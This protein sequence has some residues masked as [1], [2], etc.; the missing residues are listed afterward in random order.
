MRISRVHAPVTVLGPGRRVGVWVQ[1]C[2]L[3]CAGCASRD[4]WDPDGGREVATDDLLATILDLGADCDGLTVSGG[5]PLQQA[6]DLAQLLAAIRRSPTARAREWDILLF[7]GLA[8]HE[9]TDSQRATAALADAVVAGRYQAGD[10]GEHPLVAS[11]N[12]RL[13]PLTPTGRERYGGAPADPGARTLQVVLDDAGLTMI[14]LPRPGDLG[15]ME[16]RLRSRGVTLTGV[17]WRS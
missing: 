16:R 9:W 5:E 10:P 1:G 17:T 11:G 15:R 7:T 8:E 14:G 6:D 3:A 12:Q 2:T 13:L 4:T